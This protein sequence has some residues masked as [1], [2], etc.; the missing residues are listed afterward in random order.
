MKNKTK[1]AL[2]ELLYKT[3][4]LLGTKD[5]A[6]EENV[7]TALESVRKELEKAGYM[8]KMPDEMRETLP[9]GTRLV[10]YVKN[11]DEYPGAGVMYEDEEGYQYDVVLVENAKDGDANVLRVYVYDD[12]QSDDYTRDFH[13]HTDQFPGPV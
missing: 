12:P 1:E 10:A 6:I 3:A 5:D 2:S 9:G 11:D 8:A 7:R 13:I 4:E